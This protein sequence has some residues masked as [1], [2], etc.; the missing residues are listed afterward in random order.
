MIYQS[1]I[2]DRSVAL[3]LKILNS[4]IVPLLW[5]SIMDF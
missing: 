1:F 2:L 4:A 5:D 3:C